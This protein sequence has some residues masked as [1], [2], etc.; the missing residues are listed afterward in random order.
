MIDT[1]RSQ[2]PLVSV[3]TPFYNTAEYL[4]EC[5]ESVLRQDY[6]NWEYVLLDNRSTDGGLA[7]AQ[8]YARKDRRI[9]VHSNDRFLDQIPNYN[10]S[11]RLIS[12]DSK[13]CKMVQADDWIFPQCLSRMVAV[14]EAH[15][16]VAVVGAYALYGR[17]VYLD[18]LPY[19]SPKVP[20]REVCR[21]FFLDGDYLFGSPNSVMFRSSVVRAKDPFFDEVS[22]V[23][24]AEVCFDILRRHDFGFVHEVLTFTRRDNESIMSNVKNYE[25]MALTEF[26]CLKKFGREFF[27]DAEYA[28]LE[29]RIARKYFL[30]LGEGVVRR[31]PKR[32]WD[33]HRRGMST[34]GARFTPAMQAKYAALAFLRLAGNP[35]DT[36]ERLGELR[37]RSGAGELGRS[38]A[39]LARGASPH[40]QASTAPRDPAEV[41]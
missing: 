1:P 24:D 20:G 38:T 5:I 14:A 32:F 6:Q 33:F 15:P 9:R 41:A 30:A 39:P 4:R 40:V 7:I 19:P 8:E 31:R 2:Q 17:S 25:P 21:R 10:A 12:R 23:Q 28:R 29:R 34:V 36:I 13:Y 11:L 37:R 22:P 18:G 3:V 27:D 16:S 35:L 26:V